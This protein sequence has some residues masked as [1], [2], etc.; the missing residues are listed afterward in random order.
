MEQ[1]KLAWLITT[2]SEVQILLPAPADNGAMEMANQY[3]ERVEN[4]IRVVGSVRDE[5]FSLGRWC[6]CAIGHA[7]KD[8]YFIAR[9]FNPMRDVESGRSLMIEIGQFFDIS[10]V[11][12]ISL[13]VP[14]VGY[15][16]ARK[17]VLAALRV[18]L[19]EKMAQQIDDGVK[20]SWPT[21][22]GWHYICDPSLGELADTAA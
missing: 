21:R 4:L 12:A 2:R 7:V 22:G 10:A 15:V 18:L 1:Q 6:S 13:F 17:D 9:G 3:I 20:P 5:D 19:L 16:G 11:R 8:A 14:Q